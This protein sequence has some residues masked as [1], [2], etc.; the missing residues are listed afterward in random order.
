MTSIDEKDEIIEEVH[1][2]LL[3]F[4]FT[5]QLFISLFF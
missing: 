2:I 4:S 1:G 5:K 3:K